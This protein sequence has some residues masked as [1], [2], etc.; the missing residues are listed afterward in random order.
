MR[1]FQ[2]RARLL[3]AA[4]VVALAASACSADGDQE[5]L[6]RV[7]PPT[8]L[9][10][11][12]PIEPINIDAVDGPAG[13]GPAVETVAPEPTVAEAIGELADPLIVDASTSDLTVPALT[14]TVPP[15]I[16]ATAPPTAPPTPVPTAA[17]TPA[18]TGAPTPRVPSTLKP[19]PAPTPTPTTPGPATPDTAGAV[20]TTGSAVAPITKP[21]KPSTTR[22]AVP[23]KVRLAVVG[24]KC[25]KTQ[26][27][28]QRATKQGSQVVCTRTKPSTFV[29]TAVATPPTPALAGLNNGPGFD[30]KTI[31][32]GLIGTTTNPTWS[33]ISKAISA[34]FEARIAAINRRGGIAGQYPIR[35]LFRDANYDPGVTLAELASTQASVVGYGSIL[36]TPATEAAVPFLRDNQLLASPASQ[37]GRWAKEPN[38][39]PVFNSYQIQAISGVSYFLEQSPGATVCSVSIATSFGDAGAEGFNFAATDLGARVGAT[40]QMGSGD[41][42]AAPV[43]GQLAR[44][45]CQ[46]VLTT[47]A[48]QQLVQLVMGAA[49]AGLTFRWIALGAGFS[50]RIITSQTSKVFEATCWV[51]GDGPVWGE[52]QTASLAADLLVSDNRFWTENPDVGL[53]F[54]YTQAKVWE[55]ILERAIANRD[56]S[57][58]G[59]L[60]A[61]RTAG[62]IDTGGLGSPIDYSQPVRL[63]APRASI[64]TV[65]GSYKNS[66]RLLNAIYSPASASRFKLR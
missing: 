11:T 47:L 27:N 50:D 3:G 12:R 22:A 10:G 5:S 55:A 38:L 7:A 49:R 31:T 64:Y 39:L 58:A 36:G 65:D 56:L 28:Q 19:T 45:G 51:I 62:L 30:G 43:L 9:A 52:P 66:I 41:V 2:T 63:S 60:Q 33:N 14:P 35:V 1:I 23:P 15:T 24:A 26:V 57:R 18:P 42:N 21:A 37:E 6:D 48:P 25:L 44:G 16:A 34:G 61:S 29:W 32:L 59:L 4:L 20:T 17:P 54:G 40:L 53:T 8:T 46:G 13:Q